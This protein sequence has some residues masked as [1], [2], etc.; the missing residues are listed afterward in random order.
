[1]SKQSINPGTLSKPVGFSQV[2]KAGNMVFIAG[3]VSVDSKGEVVGKADIEAQAR[4]VYAN[5][6]AAVKAAGGKK[7]DLAATTTYLVNREHVPTVRRVREAFYGANPPTS[8][9]VIVSGLV[10]PEYLMEVEAIAVIGQ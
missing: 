6:E 8:T 7:E 4:Q 9:L 5:L 2:V 3:Q 10:R 1:M